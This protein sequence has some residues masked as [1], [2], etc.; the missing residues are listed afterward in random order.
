MASMNLI[1]LQDVEDLGLAGESV[2]VSPGFGRNYLIPKGLA[3]PAS[4]A[5]L[6][7]I[8]AQKEKI[9]AKRKADLEAAQALAVKIADMVVEIPMQASDDNHLFGSVTERVVCEAYAAK[10]VTI[11]YHR[12]RMDK[13]IRTLGEYAINIKL[14]QDVV[15]NG[16]IVIVRA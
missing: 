6:K 1:L 11:E 16:K 2:H 8:E 10:G 14:H 9:V 4:A 12:I 3:A 15:A 7:Q 13:H 5:A